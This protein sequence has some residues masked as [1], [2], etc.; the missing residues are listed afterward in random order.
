VIKGRLPFALVEIIY[1]SVSDDFL[2]NDANGKEQG[3]VPVLLT[4]SRLSH[5]DAYKGHDM[6]IRALPLIQQRL[7]EK[8]LYR[9]VGEGNGLENLRRLADEYDVSTSVEF[10]GRLEKRSLLAA[11]RNCDIFIMPSRMGTRTDGLIT[12]EGFGIV[13][14]EAAAAGKPV[15]G[16]NQGGAPEAFRDG[17]TGIAVNPFSVPEIVDAVCTLL[18]DP[19]MRLQMG[20]AGKRLVKDNFSMKAFDSQLAALLDKEE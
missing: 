19:D 5:K 20:R 8:V 13:Y 11:Y 3:S 18:E 17:S 9:M 1:P 4:V 12:G 7:G 2:N 10:A 6:V 14:I 15:I 16:S